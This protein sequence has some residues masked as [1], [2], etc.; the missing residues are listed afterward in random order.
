[1]SAAS[2]DLRANAHRPRDPLKLA[3]AIHTL[4]DSG[5]KPRDIASALRL[6]L[7]AVLAGLQSTTETDP[8]SP[9]D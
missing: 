4:N 8:C 1:M 7:E 5:L 2:Y 9:S 6:D 3:Q